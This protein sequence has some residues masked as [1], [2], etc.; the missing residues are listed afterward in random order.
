[1]HQ[2]VSLKVNPFYHRGDLQTSKNFLEVAVKTSTKKTKTSFDLDA[3]IL[4]K[5]G[6][7]TVQQQLAVLE[8]A[9]KLKGASPPD[10]EI[11]MTFVDGFL[12]GGAA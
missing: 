7:L 2:E 1:M 12:P 3:E 4:E 8:M 10:I 5:F 9:V 11:A 6:R